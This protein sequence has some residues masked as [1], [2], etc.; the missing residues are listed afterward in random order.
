M[1]VAEWFSTNRVHLLIA[2]SRS[3]KSGDFRSPV[4][5]SPPVISVNHSLNPYAF[6]ITLLHEMAHFN[7]FAGQRGGL[8]LKGRR[9][10]PPHGE[11]WK[12][13]FRK[14]TGPFLVV[15]IFPEPLLEALKHHM[16]NPRAATHTDP[17]LARILL[18]YD[19]ESHGILIESLAEGR[20][21]RT[22][23]GMTFRKGEK[24]RKRYRCVKL[25]DMRVYLFSPLARVFPAGS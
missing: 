6:L 3:S 23:S 14:L 2:R 8:L 19:R 5:G 4:S 10:V 21:F 9:R 18:Y 13:E 7:V 16:K 17:H 20:V 1:P 11:L 15:E 12:E 22:A 25:P 24:L